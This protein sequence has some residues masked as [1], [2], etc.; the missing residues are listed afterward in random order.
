VKCTEISKIEGAITLLKSSSQIVFRCHECSFDEN[1]VNGVLAKISRDYVGLQNTFERKLN[2][3]TKKIDLI[4]TALGNSKDEV[5]SECSKVNNIVE[6]AEKSIVNGITQ[7]MSMNS[8]NSW[9]EVVKKSTKRK[10]VVLIQPKND[11]TTRENMKEA[12]K[13]IHTANLAIDQINNIAN[14]GIAV[15]C[16]N[17]ET[18]NRIIDEVNEKLKDT[19]MAKIPMIKNPK[20]KIKYVN[21]VGKSDDEIL[22]QLKADNVAI[23]EA[24]IWKM[25]K[26][27]KVYRKG[28]LSENVENIIFETDKVTYDNIMKSRKVKF[29][30]QIVMTV[31]SIHIHR[32]FNCNG[33]GHNASDCKNQLSCAKCSGHHKSID[34]NTEVKKCINCIKA[35]V[36]YKLNININHVAWSNECTIYKRRLENG[37]KALKNMQ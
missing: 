34:C 17:E 13:V 30:W 14:N 1:N 2:E 32:C 25:I 20:I 35:N 29:E 4:A 10:S 23:H 21:S 9:N 5:I 37:K 27:E 19:A 15:T 16:A 22:E 18:R 7:A 36:K 33:F 31:D 3:M 11:N 26:R 6:L 8:S 28:E 24:A 12:L